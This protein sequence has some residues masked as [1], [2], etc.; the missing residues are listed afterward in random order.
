M[1]SSSITCSLCDVTPAGNARLKKEEGGLNHSPI[2]RCVIQT[3]GLIFL[4]SLSSSPICCS[5]LDFL[6]TPSHVFFVKQRARSDLVGSKWF[7]AAVQT[8]F[9]LRANGCWQV[10]F[11]AR[12]G[13]S[14]WDIWSNART[15]QCITSIAAVGC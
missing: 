7:K 14:H 15:D 4:R 12:L 1:L 6:T 5:S 11:K 2:L 13:F 8:R 9:S 3:R 10:K